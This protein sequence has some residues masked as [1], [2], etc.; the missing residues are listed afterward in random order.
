MRY[1]QIGIVIA[2]PREEAVKKVCLYN[3][4]T[5]LSEREREKKNF[6]CSVN[7]NNLP[8]VLH[9]CGFICNGVLHSFSALYYDPQH[10][11]R[12]SYHISIFDKKNEKHIKKLSLT[13]IF[14]FQHY[15]L[16]SLKY[17]SNYLSIIFWIIPTIRTDS[18]N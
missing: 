14:T 4:T 13:W 12:I 11:L 8:F 3:I 15:N 16:A 6:N 18:I 5:T 17:L 1:P 9:G 7:L 10:S 2:A